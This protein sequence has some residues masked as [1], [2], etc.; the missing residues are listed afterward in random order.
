MTQH[1]IRLSTLLFGGATI[2][3]SRSSISLRHDLQKILA[4]MGIFKLTVPVVKILVLH[5]I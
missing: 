2:H 3:V 1:V 5:I 4:D